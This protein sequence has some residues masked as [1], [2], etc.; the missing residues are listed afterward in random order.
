VD[1]MLCDIFRALKPDG[2]VFFRDSFSE[3]QEIEY[4]TDKKKC[5][6]PLVKTQ[7][8]LTAMERNGFVLARHQDFSGYPIYK[9][10]KRR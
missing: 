3:R 6:L 10:T 5:G 7:D 9:F 1:G 4:C 2:S 8:F